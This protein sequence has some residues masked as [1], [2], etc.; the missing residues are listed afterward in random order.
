MKKVIFFWLCSFLSYQLLAQPFEKKQ[1]TDFNFDSRGA[2]FPLYPDLGFSYN[3]ESTIFF[4]AHQEYSTNLMMMN[5]DPSSDSF[6]N[7]IPVTGNNYINI[8]PIAIGYYF[9]PS[10]T[11]N[12]IWQTNENGNWDIVKKTYTDSNWT[13]K[14]FLLDSPEDEINPTWILDR[15]KYVFDYHEFEFLFEKEN[16]IYLYHQKDTIKNIESIFEGN[17]TIC[18]THPTGAYVYPSGGGPTPGLYVASTCRLN[19][20]SSKIMYRIRANGDSVWGPSQVAFDD[21][22]SENPRFFH[23]YGDP[24]LSF[25]SNIAESKG[26]YIFI[27][28]NQFGQN[29]EAIPLLDHPTVQTSDFV[30]LHYLIITSKVDKEL[31][32]NRTNDFFIWSPHAYKYFNDDTVKI[33]CSPLIGFNDLLFST[34]VENTKLAVGNLGQYPFGYAISYTAWEDSANGHINLFGVKRVDAVGDINDK[35]IAKN[36]I[37]Y[38]NYP[39]PFNPKTIIKYDLL[40]RGFITLKVYDVLGNEVASLV[41]EEKDAGEYSQVY[42][43]SNLASGIYVYRLSAGNHHLSRK[44]ILLK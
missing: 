22:F 24:S 1:I 9:Y 11:I 34:H 29:S 37:L 4:E 18:Y 6:F 40:T 31:L 28:V 44:M 15:S 5:Y 32:S 21:G 12:L 38:Q 16:S 2:S 27:D 23:I 7:P 26:I 20:D 13:E 17:D 43:G 19:N 3:S 35:I 39:N 14:T 42:N 30:N 25:E 41:N 10:L 8:N 33:V 36:F